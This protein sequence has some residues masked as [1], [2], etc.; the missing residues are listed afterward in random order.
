LDDATHHH[1]SAFI[2]KLE[3]VAPLTSDEKAALLRLPLRVH[4]VAAHQDLAREGDTSSECFL[5]VEGF[6]CRYTFT[7]EGK[8]QILSF[9]I[10]GD[11]PDLQSLYLGVMDHSLATLVPSKLVFMQ[12]GDLRTFMHR[13]PRLGDLLWH[14][15]LIEAAVYRQ[16]IVGLGRRSAQ[17]RIAHLLC[18]LLVR[19]RAVELVGDHTFTL[20]LTQTELGDALGLSTTHVDEMLQD[21]SGNGLIS[22]HSDCLK[23][24]NWEELQKAGDFDPTYLHLKNRNA[25]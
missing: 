6:A 20:P 12:Q 25:F 17:S 5:I 9:H 22:L 8:R 19:L 21:L 14:D 15:T 7:G 1:T 18:E 11:M 2:R 4:T 16:W 13:H 10:S 3:K 24:L 23:V